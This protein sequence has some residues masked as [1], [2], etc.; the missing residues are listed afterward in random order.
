MVVKPTVNEGFCSHSQR[1]FLFDVSGQ[2]H[3]VHE[4]APKRYPA[5]AH[6]QP[7][8]RREGEKMGRQL[9]P[10]AEAGSPKHC[11]EKRDEVFIWYIE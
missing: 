6:A 5:V 9:G 1:L 11:P 4:N 3:A 10:R 2:L 7:R 8:K